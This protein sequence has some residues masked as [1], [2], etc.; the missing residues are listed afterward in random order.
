[1]VFRQSGPWDSLN[2]WDPFYSSCASRQ[3]SMEAHRRLLALL[4]ENHIHDA[5]HQMAIA[6]YPL[7]IHFLSTYLMKHSL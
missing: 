6:R 5:N 7:Q 4:L 1:M 2:I 3:Y